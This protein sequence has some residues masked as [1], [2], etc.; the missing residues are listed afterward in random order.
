MTVDSP[1][2]GYLRAV[3]AQVG[4]TYPVGAVLAYLTDAPDEPL[5]GV[6]GS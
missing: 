2:S 3:V 4:E 1:V 5:Q 6:S